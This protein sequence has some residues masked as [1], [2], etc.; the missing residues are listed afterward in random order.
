MDM[1]LAENVENPGRP[2]RVRTVVKGQGEGAVRWTDRTDGPATGIDH[3]ATVRDR[4]RDRPGR[5]AGSDGVIADP[6][7]VMH[8]PLHDEGSS[9]REQDSHKDEPVCLD[10]DWSIALA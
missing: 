4:V 8:V 5:P 6:G 9:Q 1:V 3:R 2:D 7:Q 10:A